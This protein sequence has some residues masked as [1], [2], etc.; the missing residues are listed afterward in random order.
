VNDSHGH[1]IGDE[2]LREFAE[3]VMANLRALDYIGRDGT[4][5]SENFGRYGGEE[6]LLV[7]PETDPAGARI[8]AERIR[9]A[10]AETVFKTEAGTLTIT[11]SFGITEFRNGEDIR[12]TLARADQALYRAKLA[13]RNR[14]EAL[15]A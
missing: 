9:Q 8:C 3:R 13:G 12:D 15:V 11:V 10:V 7:L 4:D 2:V 1:L 6:F 14:V 5:T